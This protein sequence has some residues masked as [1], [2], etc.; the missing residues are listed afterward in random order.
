MQIWLTVGAVALLAVIGFGIVFALRLERPWLQPIAIARAVL[1]LA[2]LTV[3]LNGVI[4]NAGWVAVFLAVMII[5]ATWVVI[6]RLQ[7]RMVTGVVIAAVIAVASAVPA[8]VVFVTGAVDFTPRYVLAVGGIIIGN[9]MTVSTL[10]GR[11]LAASFGTNRDEIEGWLAL[12]ATPRQASRRVVRLAASTALIPSTDQTRTTG[13]VTLPGAFV[14]A[15]FAGASVVQAAEFQMLVLASILVAG[16]LSVA[17]LTWIFG[18]PRVI[19]DDGRLV[20]L[21]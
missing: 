18:A 7:L 16:A 4:S 12:G 17:C 2:I 10:M 19:P 21:A 1:Q 13:I 15:I 20:V 6:R 9:G 3:I 11:S 8:T 5:A 14:G